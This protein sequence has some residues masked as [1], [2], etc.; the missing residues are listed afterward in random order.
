MEHYQLV[1]V[2]GGKIFTGLQIKVAYSSCKAQLL[3]TLYFNIFVAGEI[4]QN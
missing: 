3:G 1:Y 2:K 4:L